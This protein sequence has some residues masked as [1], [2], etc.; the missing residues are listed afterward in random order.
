[1]INLKVGLKVTTERSSTFQQQDCKSDLINGTGNKGNVFLICKKN[2]SELMLVARVCL[3]P[4][5]TSFNCFPI[6]KA[7]R[8]QRASLRTFA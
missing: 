7:P 1:M 8:I 2:A 6:W 3:Q 4:G 5:G